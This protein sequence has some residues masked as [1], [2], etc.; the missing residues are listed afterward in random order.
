[1][2]NHSC[3]NADL[4][5]RIKSTTI[6]ASSYCIVC[7][8]REPHCGLTEPHCEPAETFH[9]ENSPSFLTSLSEE[10]SMCPIWS[11]TQSGSQ[12][13]KHN[14][15]TQSA[16]CQNTY[17][18]KLLQSDIF[19]NLWIFVITSN[20]KLRETYLRGYSTQL[21]MKTCLPTGIHC[22]AVS[23]LICQCFCQ[24]EPM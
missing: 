2:L 20:T 10:W 4:Q 16:Q 9:Y 15:A 8:S 14:Q 13:I 5:S 1:M 18:V 11:Y 22:M 24:N 19:L 23:D 7:I 3:V 17:K 6:V 12:L 21:S